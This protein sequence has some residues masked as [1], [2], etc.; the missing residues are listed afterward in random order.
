MKIIHKYHHQ[1]EVILNKQTTAC[2]HSELTID[3]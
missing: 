2:L 3:K 1:K